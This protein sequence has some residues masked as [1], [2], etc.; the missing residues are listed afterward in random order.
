[1][2]DNR[3][4]V[5]ITQ[6]DTNGIGWEIIIKTFADSRMAEDFVPVIYG[7]PKV[8]T[9][10][11]NRLS[12]VDG[13]VYNPIQSVSQARR[14]KVNI[15]DCGPS[16]INI[17]PGKAT[18]EAGKAAVASLRAA[19]NALKAGE[20]DV[21][22]TAPINKESVQSDD[23]RYTG[24]TEFLA[25]ELGGS[26]MM[27]MCSDILRVGLVTIHIPLAEVS[28]SIS[29]ELIVGSLKRLRET[30]RSDF[31]IVEPRIAVL[32]LNPH[33]GDGGLLGTEEQEI[34]RPAIQEAFAQKILAFGPFAADG[35]FASGGFARYDA[36]LAMYHDQGLAPFKTLSPE[37]VNFT[38]A[39]SKIRTSPD[40]GVAYDIAGKDKADPQSMREAIYAAI[41]IFENRR[42]WAE[43][44]AN[45]LQRY[46]REKGRDVSV[47]DLPDTEPQD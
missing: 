46:E 33:S 3:I 4:R 28:G 18:A 9:Y 11:K 47:Q 19:V 12:D 27:I 26:P 43:M 1:M 35:L 20:I 8:A 41:D 45:P 36:V 16:E 44:N 17:E 23:F 32:A 2:S 5:G 31:G 42:R 25:A 37:G 30:L 34:I 38:A 39:L 24:H 10:Y 40:H 13:F 7:S 6:G 14:G 29:K 15:I 22:V 21:L